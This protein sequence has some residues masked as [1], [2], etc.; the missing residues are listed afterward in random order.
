MVTD[1]TLESEA[2]ALEGEE[3]TKSLAFIKRTL[4]WRP[5]D[6]ASAIEL[7]QDPWISWVN[8]GRR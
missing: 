1:A 6:R 2:K 4:Q 3:K 5:E 8:K 7:L